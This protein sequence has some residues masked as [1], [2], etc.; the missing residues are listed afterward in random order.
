[1]HGAKA[2]IDEE[3]YM[4]NQPLVVQ[5]LDATDRDA[6]SIATLHAESWRRHYRGAYLDTYLDGDVVADRQL[7]WRSRLVQ[8]RGTQFTVIARH[9]DEIAGF[10]HTILDEDER[11]GSLL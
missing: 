8:P 7:V 10:A 3:I 5:Y 1:L 11:W 2:R 9:D 6:D 4:S